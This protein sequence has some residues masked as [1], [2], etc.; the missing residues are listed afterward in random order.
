M[1]KLL[2]NAFVTRFAI[3]KSTNYEEFNDQP[4]HIYFNFS[5]PLVRDQSVAP[6]KVALVST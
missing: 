3:I 1:I 2:N 6:E 4:T 5:L